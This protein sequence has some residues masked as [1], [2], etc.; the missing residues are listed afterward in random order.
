MTNIIPESMR[1]SR[2][3]K[4]VISQGWNWRESTGE[5]IQVENCPFCG[6]GDFKF[7]MACCDPKESSRDS[8]Y[9]CHHGSCSKTGN[10]RTLSE[11]LGIRIAG[12]ESRSEW[13]GK[14]DSKPDSLPDVDA[15]H[16]A[17]LSDAEAMDY[18][19][20]VRKFTKEIIDRQKLGLKEKVWFRKSGETKALVIPYL[21]TEGNVTYA[22]YRTLPPAEKDFITPSGWDAQLFN[23]QVLQEGCKEVIFL[24]GECDVLSCM[25]NG[26][27]YA[28]G[29]P[30][31]NVKKAEWIAVLDKVAPEKIYLLYD[32]DSVG[33]RAAQEM[34]S[35]IGIDKC[36]KI[37]LPKE[38]KDI[39]EF[40]TKGGTLEAFEKFKA[41]AQLYDITGVTSSV[42]ALTQLEDEL[43]GK[44]DLA[45]KYVFQ[46]PELNRLI[47]MEDGDVLDIVAPEKVGKT[48]FGLNIL[49][50][51]VAQ[52]GE[53]GLLVCLEMTQARLARKWVSLVTGFEDTITEPGSPEAKAKLEELKAGCVT[54]RSIQ[55]SRGADLYFAYPLLVKE[56]EDVFKLIRDCIRRY[57]VK[58]V[59]FDNVQRLCDDTLKNQ[60]HRTV[61]LSQISKGF[62]KLAKDYRIKLIRIL[63]PKRIEKGMT[64]STNDVDGSSQIA[65]DCDGMI[66]LWRAVVGE[67]KKSEWETQQQGFQESCMSFEPIMKVSVGLSRYSA[68]G[69]TKLYYD[70]ARSQV[71]SLKEE[72]KVAMTPVSLP[73]GSI[74]MEG[75]GYQAV[76]ME[77]PQAV[78]IPTEGKITI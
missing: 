18:L 20:S 1:N 46:W 2:G 27:E 42:D 62:A 50:H 63:Q 24:E 58:W 39:N 31:A 22:K 17:L 51:M 59:M 71:R 25:S 57:G 15:C 54:A 33:Q 60:G 73:Q 55:Q 13:A 23:G 35:R 47:G 5:Q 61:Q 75:G 19:L 36:L 45:P 3:L 74:P 66:T 72:Q 41:A 38:V 12:V 53:D 6:K 29:V 11:H 49:D 43:K 56:P 34:A 7:Y 32:N 67:Q 28:V 78:S 37:T 10:Y 40:F 65:K 52:Y 26:I 76:T 44:V 14:G 8:L 69:T 68:G 48:T 9:F 16:A 64:I 4:L 30:G 21:S 70:G 77:E